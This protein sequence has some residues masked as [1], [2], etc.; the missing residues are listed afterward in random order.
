MES[1]VYNKRHKPKQNTRLTATDLEALSV[2]DTIYI[3]VDGFNQ[4]KTYR[5]MVYYVS[6]TSNL[7]YETTEKPLHKDTK[8][9]LFIRRT[10]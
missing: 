9:I 4:L 1:R 6:G 5:A 8:K 7:R 10:A 2:G 3:I